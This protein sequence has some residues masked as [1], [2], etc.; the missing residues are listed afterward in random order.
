MMTKPAEM[1]TTTQTGCNSYD[2]DD[3]HPDNDKE[4]GKVRRWKGASCK[5]HQCYILK[6]WQAWSA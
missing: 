5:K 6:G 4:C 1:A 3:K 2:D